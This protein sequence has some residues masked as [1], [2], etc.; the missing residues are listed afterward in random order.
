MKNPFHASSLPAAALLLAVGLTAGQP[1]SRAQTIP[2]GDIVVDLEKFAH[3]PDTQ[4]KFAR[5]NVLRSAP[6]GRIFAND[7]RGVLYLISADGKTVTPYLDLSGASALLSDDGERGFQSFAFH[8]D[9][10]TAGAAG[11]GKFYTVS[12]QND[13]GVTPTFTPGVSGAGRDHDEVLTEWTA[14]DPSAST[15]IPANANAPARE[16]I[17]IVRPNGNHNGGYISF[18][19]LATGADRGNLY[20]GMGD[21]GGGGDPLGLAQMPGKAYGCI[22]RINPLLPTLTGLQ[23]SA[24]GAYGIP[25]DN[26]YKT[27]AAVLPE[28]YMGGFRNP[29]RFV[30]DR[31]TGRMFITDIGQGHIEEVDIAQAGGNYGWNLREGSFVYNSDGSNGANGRGDTASTGLIYPIAEYQHFGGLGNAVTAGPVYRDAAIPQLTDRFLFS[32]FPS[33]TPYTIDADNLP[34]GGSS[35]ITE[36]RLREDGVEGSFLSFMQKVNPNAGRADLR[37]GSDLSNNIYFLDKADGVIRRVV[38][39]VIPPIDSY[40]VRISARQ[41]TISRNAGGKAKVVIARAGAN[42]D[43]DLTVTYRLLGSAVNGRD[44]AMR[45][46][47]ATIRAGQSDVKVKIVPLESGGTGKVKMVLQAGQGYTLD[48]GNKRVK[49]RIVD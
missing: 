28:K 36:L 11:Y 21:S 13:T 27:N 23:A 10:N 15:F 3:L 31:A 42:L 5:A 17:R 46:G 24:N 39:T 33:G 38:T 32:D 37:L 20:W 41:N 19:P 12:S 48:E 8:P 6:D 45:A 7:Q 14:K 30:W 29:Q 47:T 26:P 34:D 40:L 1:L 25:S 16:V 9:F 35:A 22:L 4:G 2:K 43:T 44:Y 49:I 18:N